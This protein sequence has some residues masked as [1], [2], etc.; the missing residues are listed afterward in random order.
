VRRL[1][2]VVRDQ[3]DYLEAWFALSKVTAKT[4]AALSARAAARVRALDPLVAK[5]PSRPR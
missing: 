5:P 3:P 1:E 2:S 4:D